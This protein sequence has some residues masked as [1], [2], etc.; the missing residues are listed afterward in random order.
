MPEPADVLAGLDRMFAATE[1]MDQVTTLV[2]FVLDPVTGQLDLSNAG[3][4]PPLVVAGNA[5]P[6]LL[7]TEPDT[8]LGISSERGHHK[9]F[10]QP[11]NTVALYSDGLVENRKRSVDSGL[12]EL[13]DVASSA[14]PEA[15]GDP[16]QML[17]YLVESM[18]D[19][20]EQDDDVTLLAVQLPVI[21]AAP[22]Q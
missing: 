15:V 12:G 13:V 3:H 4:L 7:D 18:L 2:Y 21:D 6:F 8:P 11:G 9:F 16:Q 17:E 5:G 14:P 1:G 20:Y 19:G 22:E 10:V